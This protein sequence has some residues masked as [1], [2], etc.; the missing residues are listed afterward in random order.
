MKTLAAAEGKQN[1]SV[2]PGAKGNK[3]GKVRLP[4][5]KLKA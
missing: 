3:N 5:Y 1:K 4:F 2:N